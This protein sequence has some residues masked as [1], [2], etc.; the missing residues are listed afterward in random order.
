MRWYEIKFIPA[1]EYEIESIFTIVLAAKT[2]VDAVG[3]AC[4][5][6]RGVIDEDLRN[7]FECDVIA[8]E[9]II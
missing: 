5:M 9:V 1:W 6:F 3:T 4:A 2:K 8:E 7:S